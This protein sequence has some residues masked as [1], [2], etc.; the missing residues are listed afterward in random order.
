MPLL[1]VQ[2]EVSV[3]V[4]KNAFSREEKNVQAQTT[5]TRSTARTKVVKRGQSI[6][7]PEQPITNKKADIGQQSI[8]QEPQPRIQV[9]IG[10][11][12]VR[13]TPPASPPP[14]QRA[15]MPKPTL[16]LS[17]YLQQR[18]AELQ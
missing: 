18:K 11:I 17:E 15:G 12:D 14:R 4:G 3:Q 2:P 16:T 13:A 9:R 7:A 10:R 8:D 6:Q 5:A 1:I